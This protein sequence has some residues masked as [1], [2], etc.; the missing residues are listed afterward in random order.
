MN[1]KAF[2]LQIGARTTFA[3]NMCFVEQPKCNINPQVEVGL[4]AKGHF[5]HTR[6]CGSI[7]CVLIPSKVQVC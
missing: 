1:E 4:S 6:Y 3:L 5:A 7:H 2:A